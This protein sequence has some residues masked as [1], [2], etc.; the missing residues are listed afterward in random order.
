MRKEKLEIKNKFYSIKS[1]VA[2]QIKKMELRVMSSLENATT[3][4][5]L[6]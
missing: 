2:A 5:E 6:Q 1:E 4:K 3:E